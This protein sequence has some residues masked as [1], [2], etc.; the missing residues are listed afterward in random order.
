MEKSEFD[1][2]INDFTKS[3]RLDLRHAKVYCGRAYA[4]HMTGKFNK[5]IADC[6]E[7]LRLDPKHAMAYYN[8]G[9]AYA[10]KGDL[11]QGDC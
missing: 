1:K 5:A 6:I 10:K 4:Y 7:A 8:R 2:A 11:R 3:I 9:L